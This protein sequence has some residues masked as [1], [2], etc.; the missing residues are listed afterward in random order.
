MPAIRISSYAKQRSLER[1]KNLARQGLDVAGFLDEAGRALATA[2]PVDADTLPTPYWYTLDPASQLITSVIGP[3]CELNADDVMRFEYL[4]DDFNKAADVMR[5]PRGV[6]TLYE[7]TGGDPSRSPIYCEY[8]RPAGQEHEALVAL[9][10]RNGQN[11]GTVRLVRAR[12]RPAFDA[13][14]LDFLRIVAPHLA[15]GIRSGL[16]V[17]E[18]TDPEGPDAPAIVVLDQKLSV[19]SLTS[20]AERWLGDLPGAGEQTGQLPPAVLSVAASS[21]ARLP[22]QSLE[23][24]VARVFSPRRGWVMLHGMALGGEHRRVAV[25]IEPAHP[26]RITPLLIAAYGLTGREEQ[27]ARHVLLGDSTAS[28]AVAL[29]VSPYT[30]QEYLKHIFDKVG[31]NSRRELVGKVFYHHY[32]PR[33]QSNAQRVLQDEPIRGGPFPGDRHRPI[34]ADHSL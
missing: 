13:A 20:G 7:A 26:A 1:I 14:E 31:V 12:G 15:D 23:A 22:G 18:A 21:L 28:I 34:H 29:Q 25:I 10:T 16:T 4:D 27:V 19:Q 24:E 5:H 6:Q 33:V 17:G 3:H 30:V 11:W 2:V 9:R 32:D 8:M